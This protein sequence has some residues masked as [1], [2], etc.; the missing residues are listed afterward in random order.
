MFAQIIMG[1]AG[2]GKSSYCTAIQ[3][4]CASNKRTIH[5][6]NCDPAAEDLRYEPTID[7][8]DLISLDDVSDEFGPNGG[9]VYCVEYLIKNLDWL[10]EQIGEFGEDY[11]LLD[12]PGQVELYTHYTL[13]NELAKGLSTWGYQVCSVYLIDSRFLMDP[14][15]FISATM[16]AMACQMNLELPHFNVVA[17]MD[18]VKRDRLVKKR[19]LD[20]YLTADMDFFLTQLKNDVPP[21]F[22]ALT[23]AIAGIVSEYSLVRFYPVSVQ[24]PEMMEDFLMLV[25]NAIQYGEDAEPREPDDEGPQEE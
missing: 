12:M 15:T 4:H 8:R 22:R 16:M 3:E 21:K 7:I 24:D 9:L 17:K 18:M 14:T 13:I 25:D 5:I 1:P 2:S 10:Q 11:L 20:Y 6:M 23:E 19:F